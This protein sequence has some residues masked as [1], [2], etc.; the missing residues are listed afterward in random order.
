MIVT[1]VIPHPVEDNERTIRY[2][3]HFHNFN[4]IMVK[5]F[6]S[7]ERNQN[8]NRFEYRKTVN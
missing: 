7:L 2:V 5:R 8:Y 4:D 1:M 6:K 3:E